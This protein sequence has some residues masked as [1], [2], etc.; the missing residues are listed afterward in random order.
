MEQNVS[1]PEYLTVQDN[2][3]NICGLIISPD[4]VVIAGELLQDKLI[5]R[6]G[7]EAA[8]ATC[9]SQPQVAVSRLATEVLNKISFSPN[10]FEKLVCILEKRDEEFA[11]ALRTDCGKLRNYSCS[12]NIIDLFYL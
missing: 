8:V 7:H 6:A 10:K 11:T 12:Q 5:G 9:T 4:I 3:A 1:S 2:F